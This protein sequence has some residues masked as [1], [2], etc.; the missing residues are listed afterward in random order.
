MKIYQL[1]FP[2]RNGNPTIVV[3][4]YLHTPSRKLIN[5][6]INKLGIKPLTK[7]EHNDLVKGNDVEFEN[8]EDSV[9]RYYGYAI[10]LVEIEVT[11]N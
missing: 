6:D 3:H 7:K 10:R 5:S 4:S 11:E 8:M 1:L 2:D 9:N